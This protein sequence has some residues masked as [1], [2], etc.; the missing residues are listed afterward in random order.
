VSDHKINVT[1]KAGTSFD[2]PW[3]TVGGQSEA[4]V[5]Q[6]LR[7]IGVEGDGDLLSLAASAG[8]AFQ[9]YW[10][11]SSQLGGVPVA[12]ET[13]QP[14]APAAQPVP[15]QQAAPAQTGQYDVTDRWGNTWTYGR[16]D[17]PVTQRG[18]AVVK[19]WTSQNGVLCKKWHDP[20]AGP[21][22]FSQRKPK[23]EKAELWEGD[24]VKG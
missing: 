16:V 19:T 21:E 20:A 4:E 10:T 24:W 6:N 2:A 7:A 11:A 1:V 5:A 12:T 13:T 17:A 14:A 18:P 23:I 22:W 15:Q 9:G 3:I 8:K